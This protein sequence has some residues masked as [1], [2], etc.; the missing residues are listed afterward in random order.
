MTERVQASVVRQRLPGLLDRV[1]AG[2]S[3]IITRDG[4]DVAMLGPVPRSLIPEHL[5]GS[6][7]PTSGR[8]YDPQK[9]SALLN[10][11]FPQKGKKKPE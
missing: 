3:L 9:V 7:R 4:K 5:H 2:E 11:A 1:K 6:E 8:R 10:T